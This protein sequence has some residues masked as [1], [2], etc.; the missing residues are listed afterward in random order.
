MKLNE[1][2]EILSDHYSYKIGINGIY[3]GTFSKN[4]LT[5]SMLQLKVIK[6]YPM[7]YPNLKEAEKSLYL[8]LDLEEGKE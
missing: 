5:Y 2:I 7:F 6:I 3:Q 8:G 1:I 4:Q